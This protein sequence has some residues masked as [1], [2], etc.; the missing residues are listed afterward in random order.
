MIDASRVR[1]EYLEKKLSENIERKIIKAAQEGF[2]A[3]EVDYLSDI[4][5]EKL[6]AA[7]YKVEFNPG[8]IFKFDSWTIYW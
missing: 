2:P 8:N 4:L 1:A 5:I 7:G 3:I 6:E